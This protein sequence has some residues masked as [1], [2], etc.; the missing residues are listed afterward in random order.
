M[1]IARM[2]PNNESLNGGT[3]DGI[4]PKQQTFGVFSNRG[5]GGFEDVCNRYNNDGFCLRR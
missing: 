1:T 3:V 4:L 5:K 2:R